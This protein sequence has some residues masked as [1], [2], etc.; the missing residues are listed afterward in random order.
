MSANRSGGAAGSI[1]RYAAP[2]WSTP[3]AATTNAA[4]RSRQIATTVS[5]PTSKARRAS[6]SRPARRANSRYVRVSVAS[7]TAIAS[8]VSAAWMATAWGTRSKITD[9]LFMVSGFTVVAVP[10]T[11]TSTVP[12]PNLSQGSVTRCNRGRNQASRSGGGEAAA[13][14]AVR[15]CTPGG[16]QVSGRVGRY[17][18]HPLALEPGS[19]P[20]ERG[21]VE[22]RRD[23]LDAQ[24]QR[25]GCHDRHRDHRQ[26][27]ERQGLGVGAQMAPRP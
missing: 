4:E 21:F 9:L 27:D 17:P 25:A 1:G 11:C 24:R 13:A 19:H 6:V 2:A 7:V 22:G 20:E 16:T 23:Q 26:A 15:H 10:F 18:H 8:G 14:S 3:S 12:D 5:G